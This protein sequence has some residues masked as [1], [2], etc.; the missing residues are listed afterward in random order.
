[1]VWFLLIRDLF[2]LFMLVAATPR[3]ASRGLIL[4]FGDTA[5]LFPETDAAILVTLEEHESSVEWR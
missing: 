5:R 4:T 1:M 3:C 2:F